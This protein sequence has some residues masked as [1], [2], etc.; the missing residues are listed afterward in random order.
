MSEMKDPELKELDEVTSKIVEASDADTNAEIDRN[1]TDC[2]LNLDTEP[3]KVKSPP[4]ANQPQPSAVNPEE[5]REKESSL[6][7]F[8]TDELIAMAQNPNTSESVWVHVC[9]ELDRRN[10]T[11]N[12]KRDS[13]SK[14]QN[15]P[16]FRNRMF[17]A[18]MAALAISAGAVGI[19][20]M[21]GTKEASSP[22][23]QQHSQRTESK[24]FFEL[25]KAHSKTRNVQKRLGIQLATVIE[26]RGWSERQ[27]AEN[28]AVD[29]NSISFLLRGHE[30]AF[31]V[32]K[33]MEMLLTLDPNTNIASLMSHEWSPQDRQDAIKFYSKALISNPQE[34]DAYL[35]RALEYEGLNQYELALADYSRCLE[36]KPDE[37]RALNDR[38]GLYYRLAKYEANLKDSNQLIHLIPT[39]GIGYMRRGLVYQKTGKFELAIN[40]YS[41]AIELDGPN[42]KVTAPI[43]SRAECYEELGKL[44]LAIADYEKANSVYPTAVKQEKI[45]SLKKKLFAQ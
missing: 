21:I 26:N 32:D 33:A 44:K 41:K 38:A 14:S 35:H 42:S 40:D 2:N 23:V 16:I 7:S 15:T 19:W 17:T 4:L 13:V 11:H 30:D 24:N 27:A 36:L 28:L 34:I 25:L 43:L 9:A 37:T 20:Q 18:T 5:S 10:V 22:V 6:N 1:Q 39:E 12:W 45:D 8:A 31:A 29:Q 3:T